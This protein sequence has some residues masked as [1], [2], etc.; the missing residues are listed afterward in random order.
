MEFYG[1]LIVWYCAA[2]QRNNDNTHRTTD[3]SFRAKRG[4]PQ[5][6]IHLRSKPKLRRCR[7]Q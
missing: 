4:N 1:R 7:A 5:R 3:L 6:K 2:M